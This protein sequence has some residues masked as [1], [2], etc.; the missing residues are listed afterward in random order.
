MSTHVPSYVNGNF[1][2][3]LKLKAST[4]YSVCGIMSAE[5][6]NPNVYLNYLQFDVASDYEW[7]RN[8]DL[9]TLGALIWDILSS[10]PEDW[11][12]ARTSKPT[13]VLFAYFS[14]RILALVVVVLSVLAK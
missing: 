1:V 2:P 5:I 6:L 10:L 3:V 4:T 13:P 14:A 8:V 7:S 12:I 9:A 11:R